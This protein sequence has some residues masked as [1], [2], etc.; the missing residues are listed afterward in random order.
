MTTG[1]NFWQPFG[2]HTRTHRRP[3][4]EAPRLEGQQ[5]PL[6]TAEAMVICPRCLP[7][8]PID[9]TSTRLGQ[10]KSEHPVLNDPGLALPTDGGRRVHRT[11]LVIQSLQHLSVRA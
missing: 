4:T 2:K 6:A 1:P 11:V 9:A 7:G 3:S 5:G 8:Q 10:S